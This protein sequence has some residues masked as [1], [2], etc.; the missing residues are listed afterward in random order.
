LARTAAAA[1]RTQERLRIVQPLSIPPLSQCRPGPEHARRR[2][3]FDELLL[4]QLAFLRRRA[5]RRESSAAR[6]C[7]KIAT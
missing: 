1:V 2:L 5:Q 7:S 4:A 3:A 6:P